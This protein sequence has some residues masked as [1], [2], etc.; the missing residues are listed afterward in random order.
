MGCHFLLQGIFQAQGLNPALLHC[1]QILYHL[2]YLGSPLNPI[3]LLA[4]IASVVNST[5]YADHQAKEFPSK[6][7]LV[8][9]T[10][11]DFF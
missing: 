8:T 4:A 2:S 5:T 1:R 11:V 3:I 7:Y 9:F 6:F 10:Q